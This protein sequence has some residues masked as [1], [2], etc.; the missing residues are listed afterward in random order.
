MGSVYILTNKAMPGLV[1][2]GYTNRTPEERAKELYKDRNGAVTGVPIPFDV[3]NSVFCDRARELEKLIHD[4]LNDHRVKNHKT[5]K[6]ER[7]FFRYPADKAFQKLK[8]IHQR[9]PAHADSV[10]SQE[11]EGSQPPVDE[12]S[13][14]PLPLDDR[15]WRKWTSHFLT[16]FKR[17]GETQE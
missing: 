8:E 13:Q 11:I 9:Y 10:D 4:E 6:T 14:V 2:I 3:F 15:V 7:E 1:K 17:K 16:R 12:A 5:D